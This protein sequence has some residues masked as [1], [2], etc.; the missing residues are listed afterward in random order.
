MS[1][2]L[3]HNIATDYWLFQ[4]TDELT[5]WPEESRPYVETIEFSN[6]LDHEVGHILD[7]CDD[8][9]DALILASAIEESRQ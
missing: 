2:Y 4:P 5:I 3:H 9:V 1:R 7:V 6:L 8:F